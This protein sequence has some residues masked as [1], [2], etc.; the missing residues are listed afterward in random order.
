MLKLCLIGGSGHWNYVLDGLK[1]HPDVKLAGIAPGSEGEDI[2]RMHMVSKEH[3]HTPENWNDYRE[4]LDKIKPEVIAVN[5]FFEDHA[6]VCLE[7][8]ARGCHIFSEKPVAV[9]YADLKKLRAAYAESEVHF[10]AMFGIRYTSWFLTTYNAVQNGKIGKVRLMNAQKSYK[11]GTRGGHFKSRKVYGG[12]I[13][14]VGSHA[15]DWLHWFS[16]EDFRSVFA[17]HSTIA[18]RDHGQ[19]ESTALC[20]FVFTN[21]VF[22]SVNIDYLRPGQAPSH[23]DDRIR[24]AGTEGVIEVLHQKVYLINGEREGIQE[25]PLL[26]AGESFADFLN[27]VKGT[28]Q[29]MVT[30]ADSFLITEA[31]LKARQSAD[32]EKVIYF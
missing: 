4:M 25:L 1:Q 31:C 12:T 2:S 21:E 9:N 5:C 22:G 24:I 27:Q 20:H 14:W 7:G 17:S 26:P 29:C 16:G 30:A 15:V 28:G 8:L 6:V 18:N 32:E 23:D 19:L 11:L 3:G 13:P 10:A